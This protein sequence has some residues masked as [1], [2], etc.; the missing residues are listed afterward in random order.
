LSLLTGLIADWYFAHMYYVRV[1]EI[2][3][4]YLAGFSHSR[5]RQS[6]YAYVF[7]TVL[8]VEMTVSLVL[9]AFW[10]ATGNKE[11]EYYASDIN[12]GAKSLDLIVLLVAII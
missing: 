8:G 12:S 3:Y 9:L 4:L 6:A 2:K 1:N 10:I 7:W 5:K 11:Y